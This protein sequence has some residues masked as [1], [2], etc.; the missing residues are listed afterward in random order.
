MAESL[1]EIE[2]SLNDMDYITIVSSV[3]ESSYFKLENGTII[4]AFVHLDHM[5]KDE[6]LPNGYAIEASSS[7][8]C[9]LPPE[10]LQPSSFQ[11]WNPNQL[12]IGIIEEDMPFETIHDNFSVYQ[13]SNGMIISIKPVI[14]QIDK[15]RFFKPTGESVYIVH[16]S[17]LVKVKKRK[18]QYDSPKQFT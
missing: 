13:M 17:P 1:A 9:Y 8:N 15:T 7:S 5:R 14:T 4:K 3:I 12:R 16:Q 2:K 6:K 18:D 10:H 11:P